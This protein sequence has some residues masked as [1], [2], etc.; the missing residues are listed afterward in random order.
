M[1]TDYMEER[2]AFGNS[3]SLKP[4]SQIRRINLHVLQREGIQGAIDSRLWPAPSDPGFVYLSP[5]LIRESQTTFFGCYADGH[6]AGRLSEGQAPFPV[7]FPSATSRF[8]TTQHNAGHFVR[9][10]L[11]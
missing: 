2:E 11:S 7:T 10:L 6:K 5:V 4:E 3:R 1:P 8:S 9:E